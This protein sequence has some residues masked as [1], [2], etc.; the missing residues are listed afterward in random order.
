MVLGIGVDLAE[1]DRVRKACQ[2]PRF[3]QRVFTPV[4]VAY[5]QAAAS[6]YARFAARFAAKEAVMK[7]LGCGWGPVGWQEI[8]VNNS[9]AGGPVVQL[10]GRALD[11]AA[12]Q[13]VGRVL[14]SL[15]HTRRYA[16]ATAT[17]LD[18]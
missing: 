15:S 14:L 4:E 1:I 10:S 5:C 9:P 18:V 13:G 17:T 12:R 8:E 11:V 16:V 2:S 7:A 6:P 3:V